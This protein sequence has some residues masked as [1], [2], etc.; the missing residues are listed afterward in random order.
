VLSGR[1]LEIIY[2]TIDH[3]IIT[4]AKGQEGYA[5]AISDALIK[6]LKLKKKLKAPVDKPPAADGDKPPTTVKIG[7]KYTLKKSTPGYYTAADALVGRDA[8]VTVQAGEYWVHNIANGMI[9]ITKTKGQPGSWINPGTSAGSTTSNSTTTTQTAVIGGKYTLKKNTPGFYTAAD[10]KAG[11]NQR[12]TVLAGEYTV[13][14][15]ANGMINI[16]KSK[17][18]PGSWINPETSNS[19]TTQTA[20]IGGKYTL[21]KNTPGFYTAADAKAG[22]N[23]R[24]T[25]SAGEYTVFNTSNGMINLTKVK[26]QPGSWINPK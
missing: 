8:R 22:R 20:V 2:S 19:T 7:D 21:K 5:R 13:F 4:S 1:I 23:Q 16:T 26:G 10:A 14:N 12:V 18:Q 25:V 15:I 6:Q 3:P 24:V 11:K 9:N 17:G